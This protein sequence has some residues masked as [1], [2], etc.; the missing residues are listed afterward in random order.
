[1][2]HVFQSQK[3]ESD[4]ENSKHK[5]KEHQDKPMATMFMGK[6]VMPH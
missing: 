2:E 3:T 5:L 6:Y 4:I 1:M